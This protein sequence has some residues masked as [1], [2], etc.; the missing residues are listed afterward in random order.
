MSEDATRALREVGQRLTA[1]ENNL[2]LLIRALI[3]GPAPETP[4]APDAPA[5]RVCHD[6][7]KNCPACGGK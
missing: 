7:A 2:A 3:D 6:R 1:I 4:R 5:C